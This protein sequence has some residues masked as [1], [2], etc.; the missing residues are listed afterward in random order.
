MNQR[1]GGTSKKN[2]ADTRNLSQL[3]QREG[4]KLKKHTA[5]TISLEGLLTITDSGP[6]VRYE[7]F[8]IASEHFLSVY[9]KQTTKALFNPQIRE[10][11]VNNT[12]VVVYMARLVF[13][14]FITLLGIWRKNSKLQ[15]FGN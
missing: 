9:I 6:G 8:L 4:G 2:T 3:N 11:W 7:T 13:G 10:D 14:T 12:L 1:E 15:N 5:D